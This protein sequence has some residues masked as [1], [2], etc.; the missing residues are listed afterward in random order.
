M[1]VRFLGNIKAGLNSLAF[2]PGII[3]NPERIPLFKIANFSE[4]NV[5]QHIQYPNVTGKKEKQHSKIRK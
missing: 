3:I 5:R 2:C 4:W 1:H